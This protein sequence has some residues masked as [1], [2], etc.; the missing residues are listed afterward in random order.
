LKVLGD[1]FRHPKQQEHVGKKEAVGKVLSDILHT[2]VQVLPDSIS[3]K[4][5]DEKKTKSNAV[6]IHL[7]DQFREG[8]FDDVRFA[9]VRLFSLNLLLNKCLRTPS[10]TLD[11]YYHHHNLLVSTTP[12]RIP[13]AQKRQTS[14]PPSLA[15]PPIFNR[16]CTP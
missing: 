14:L 13:N 11:Y 5:L 1:L 10:C 7:L 15:S 8:L 4:E 16:I 3:G 12:P 6:L 9:E 2:S